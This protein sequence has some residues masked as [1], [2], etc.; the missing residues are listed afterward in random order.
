MI[1]RCGFLCSMHQQCGDLNSPTLLVFQCRDVSGAGNTTDN[2]HHGGIFLKLLRSLEDPKVGKRS[3]PWE[4]S[5]GP[6]TSLCD[7]HWQARQEQPPE[8]HRFTE[9]DRVGWQC[10]GWRGAWTGVRKPEVGPVPELSSLPWWWS[11]HPEGCRISAP[12]V[13]IPSRGSGTGTAPPPAPSSSD[14]PWQSF[15]QIRLESRHT[16]LQFCFL[17]GF[18]LHESWLMLCD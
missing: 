2:T 17:N 14:F 16:K 1:R 12:T 11:S 18:P 6:T 3:R 9:H 4:G 8:R 13:N 5:P 10:S 7:N 15:G